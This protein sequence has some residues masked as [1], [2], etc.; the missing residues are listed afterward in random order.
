MSRQELAVDRVRE[1]LSSVLEREGLPRT[2]EASASPIEGFFE[3]LFDDWGGTL[4]PAFRFLPW[5]LA[6]LAAL[7]L[8]A[9][10]VPLIGARSGDATRI[11]PDAA[12]RRR[13]ERMSEHLARARAARDAGDR[14]LAARTYLL[15]LVVGLG[16]RGDL[17]FQPAWTNRELLERGEVRP[18]VRARLG[19][20]FDE[21]DPKTFGH[22]ELEDV[23]LRGLDELCDRVV[24]EGAL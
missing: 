2:E 19:D 1:T 18:E 23:D 20:L 13:R 11:G 7:G 8:V 6:F 24:A 15:A 10:I 3:W 16:E 17:E 12:A 9:L 22:A 5:I 14:L 21:L 4:A